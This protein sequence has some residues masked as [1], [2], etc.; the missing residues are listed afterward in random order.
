MRVDLRVQQL[1]RHQRVQQHLARLW[2]QAQALRQIL[3][4]QRMRGKR[5]VDAQRD[6]REEGLGIVKV[7]KA[8]DDVWGNAPV[9]LRAIVRHW[10]TPKLCRA[11]GASAG[12]KICRIRVDG[13]CRIQK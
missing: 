12:A 9:A 13:V 8:I 1:Q 3:R 11:H 7:G 4:R 5:G 10:S 6:G 2:V